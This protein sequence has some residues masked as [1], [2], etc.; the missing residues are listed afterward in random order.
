MPY[1]EVA[2]QLVLMAWL[3]GIVNG[4][5]LL[6]REVGIGKKRIDVLVRWPFTGPG[7]ERAV[8]REALELKV[9]RDRD[10]RGDPTAKGLA[11]LDE[12]LA[13]LG[14]DEGTLV[15]FDARAAAPP[16]EERTRFEARE[17]ASGRRV[18]LL[19]A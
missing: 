19:L 3:H 2:P 11:Q 15:V 14:L 5:G 10:K 6:S 9:W 17:T 12:Y 7:G 16:I 13:K 8:Q 1:P 18:T 4:K